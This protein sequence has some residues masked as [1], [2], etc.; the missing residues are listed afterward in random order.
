LVTACGEVAV[1][2]EK[3]P[4]IFSLNDGELV[5]SVAGDVPRRL[6]PEQ[7]DAS[8]ADASIAA[9]DARRRLHRIKEASRCIPLIA[10]AAMPET[11]IPKTL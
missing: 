7:P 10:S 4:A 2:L 3:K 6:E 1:L 11:S 9:S 5:G 8:N